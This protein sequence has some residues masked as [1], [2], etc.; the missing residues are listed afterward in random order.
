MEDMFHEPAPFNE[1]GPARPDA[2]ADSDVNCSYVLEYS[3]PDTI[4]RHE[5]WLMDWIL[6]WIAGTDVMTVTV[7]P[8]GNDSTA[9]SGRR[10]VIGRARHCRPPEIPKSH[11]RLLERLD[12]RVDGLTVRCDPS[13]EPTFEIVTGNERTEV[14]G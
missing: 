1:Y 11:R 7:D 13:D 12:E 3:P 2:D 6:E 14:C 8:Q 10:I 4:G 5:C 9:T